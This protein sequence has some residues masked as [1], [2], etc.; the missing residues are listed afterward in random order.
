VALIYDK[1]WLVR[2]TVIHVS[3]VRVEHT[4]TRSPYVLRDYLGEASPLLR[5]VTV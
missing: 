5:L 3:V 1:G 4:P 2:A